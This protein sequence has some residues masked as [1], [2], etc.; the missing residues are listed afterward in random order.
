MGRTVWTGSCNSWFKQGKG[1]ARV[2]AMYAGSVIHFKEMLEDF[3]GED[4]D[5][6]YNSK[7]RFRY[8]GNGITMIEEEGKDLAWYVQK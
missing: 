5:F 1:A 4:F 8:M 3:R 2:T 6:K 7:N